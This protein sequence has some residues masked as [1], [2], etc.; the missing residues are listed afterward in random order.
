MITFIDSSPVTLLKLKSH[1]APVW[2]SMT[3][4]HMVEH[5]SSALTM[6]IKNTGIANTGTNEETILKHKAHTLSN[7]FHSGTSVGDGKLKD[8]KQLDLASAIKQYVVDIQ[9][10]SESVS[11]TTLATSHFYFGPLTNEEWITFH[12]WHIH[13]HFKQFNIL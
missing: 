3:A 13:H 5:L 10:F 4:Q 7:G 11:T 2:G 8:L 1:T 6:S 12:Y 9:N